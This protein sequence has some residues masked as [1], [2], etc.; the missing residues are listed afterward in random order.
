MAKLNFT[1]EKP[2]DEVEINGKTYKLYYDDDSL[3]KYQDQAKK[4]NKSADKYLKSVQ[5]FEKMTEK[6]KED[7]EVEG[8]QMARDFVTTF[9]GK[10]SFDKMYEASGKSMINFMGLIDYTFSWLSSKTPDLDDKKKQYYTKKK[11]K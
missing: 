8:M 5:D 1:F 7:F 11:K 3:K 4:Y 6:Q 2:Y 9:Y 10:D